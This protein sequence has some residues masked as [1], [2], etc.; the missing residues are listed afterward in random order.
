[1]KAEQKQAVK[2]WKWRR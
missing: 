2:R 1:L